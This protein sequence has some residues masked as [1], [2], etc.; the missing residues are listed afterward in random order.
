MILSP[1]FGSFFLL[2][3]P[4]SQATRHGLIAGI[5]SSTI[6]YGVVLFILSSILQRRPDA[7]NCRS[8]TSYYFKSLNSAS[9]IEKVD[10]IHIL[11]VCGIV[12]STIGVIL[13]WSSICR[14]RRYQSQK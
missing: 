1:L 5:G 9:C 7:M 11:I 6:C 12:L 8:A 3:S 4:K 10:N 14:M 13:V 2:C